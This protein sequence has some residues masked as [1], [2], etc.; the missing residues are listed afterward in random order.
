MFLI[1]NIYFSVFSLC[2]YVGVCLCA[3]GKAVE[4]NKQ[5]SPKQ[6]PQPALGF[7]EQSDS[8]AVTP[9][10]IRGNQPS[11]GSDAS[12]HVLPSTTSPGHGSPVGQ[13]S[14][15]S[16]QDSDSSKKFSLAH[17]TTM[18]SRDRIFEMVPHEKDAH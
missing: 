7:P 6:L 3:V 17:H 1:F 14:D 13:A 15:T 18:G 5:R 4:L 11:E 9:A 2:V 8:S 10:R 16:G 12:A